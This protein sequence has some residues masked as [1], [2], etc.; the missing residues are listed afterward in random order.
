MRSLIY[1]SGVTGM[2]LLL[3]RFV[4]L[5]FDMTYDDL[6]FQLGLGILIVITLPLYIID[7]VRYNQ[8]VKSILR[9]NQSHES[10]KKH[11]DAMTSKDK[12][13][14]PSYPSFREQKQG[15]KWGGGNI[16]GAAAERGSRK[17][18]LD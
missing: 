12:G 18:F 6:F 11:Q 3:V 8:K 17:R 4:G 13:K 10:Q 2:A 15:L 14:N 1:F 16:H 9:G 7:K 5:L